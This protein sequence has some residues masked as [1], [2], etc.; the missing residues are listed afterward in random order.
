LDRTELKVVELIPQNAACGQ[1]LMLQ[2]VQI[3]QSA[4]LSRLSH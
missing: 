3:S 2:Y 4:L 1:T